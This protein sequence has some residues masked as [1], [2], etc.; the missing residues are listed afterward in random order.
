MTTV[1][2]DGRTLCGDTQVSRGTVRGRIKTKVFRLAYQG[3]HVLVGISGNQAHAMRI[4]EW[5]EAG[6]PEDAKPDIPGD[7]HGD[8]LLIIR[9]RAFRLESGLFPLLIE[10]PF[11]A[12][13]SGAEMAI[14]AMHCG[15]TAREAVEVACEYDIHT[16]GPITEVS[17]EP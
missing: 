4:I 15:R 3:E 7:D 9:G 2:W 14:A 11:F 1:A 6:S 8:C 10:E 12:I 16:S 13:G 5:I 17:L